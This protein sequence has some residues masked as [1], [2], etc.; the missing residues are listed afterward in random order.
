MQRSRVPDDD[1]SASVGDE[2]GGATAASPPITPPA[3]LP[4]P[5]SG[6]AAQKY[7]DGRFVIINAILLLL[8]L[9][10]GYL[11]YSVY[12]AIMSQNFGETG[13]LLRL[14]PLTFRLDG[15]RCFQSCQSLVGIPSLD[16]FQIFVIALVVINL[17][18]FFR[19][20]K[21]SA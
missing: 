18:H 20:R 21:Q 11:E 3:G 12:P 8:A 6:T 5:K 17:A 1:A 13:I 2:A 9:V 10:A 15:T 7:W 4:V 16:F 14:S 19:L